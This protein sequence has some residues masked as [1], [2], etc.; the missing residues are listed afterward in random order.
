MQALTT[1]RSHLGL[2]AEL[3][4]RVLTTTPQTMRS[5]EFGI[6]TAPLKHLGI[7]DR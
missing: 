5:L 6:T 2:V 3:V 7:E 4:G 1:C